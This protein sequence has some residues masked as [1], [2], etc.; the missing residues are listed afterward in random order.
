MHGG[1]A[2]AATAP[3]AHVHSHESAPP[4]RD[5]NVCTCLGTCCC[6][7]SV[8]APRADLAVVESLTI[9]ATHVGY[10]DVSAPVVRH[11]HALPFANGPPSA[12]LI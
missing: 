5:A 12:A 9:V 4:T 10:D 2:V 11:D 3:A 1:H 6:A 7:P 8:A